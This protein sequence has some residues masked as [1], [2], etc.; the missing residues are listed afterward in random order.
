MFR[1]LRRG[2]DSVLV[3]TCPIGALSAA[4]SVALARRARRSRMASP[5]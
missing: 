3:N 5:A 2:H 4:L 1:V